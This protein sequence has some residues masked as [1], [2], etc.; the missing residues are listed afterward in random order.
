MK[1]YSS[2]LIVLFFS[3]F[4]LIKIFGQK[5]EKIRYKADELQYIRIK[6]EPVRKLLNNVIFTQGLT[7]IKCDSAYYF[8]KQKIMEA[9]SNVI[10]TDKDSVIITANKLIYNGNKKY[11]DL[12]GDV[13]YRKKN[14]VLKTKNLV[15][16][17]INK[18]GKFR[19]KGRLSDQQNILI[20]DFGEFNSDNNYSIFNKN[21]ELISP[22]YTL[23]SDTL[24]YYSDSKIAYTYGPTEII[25]KDS[26]IVNAN[27]GEFFTDIKFTEFEKS[28][29]ETNEYF[30]EAD[31]IT[32]DE[33]KEY[34]SALGNVKLIS[35]F[36]NYIITG[37]K[38]FVDKQNNITKVYE[39]P[40]L[41]KIIPYDTF[42]LSSDTIIAFENINYN[43]RKIVAFNNVK[44]IK[45]G[46]EGKADSI[47]YLLKDSLITMFNQ[48]IIWNENNQ[49]TSDTIDFLLV[50]NLIKK[51]I[52]NKNSFIISL[53][54]I[55]NYNQIKG[56]N[57]VSY[58]D[59]NNYINNIQVIGNGESIYFALNEKK[60]SIIGLNYMIC[61]DMNIR[62]E[63]NEIKDITFFKNPKA[64]LIPPHEINE[65]DL[66]L[67][68]F[69]WREDERPNLE[70]VVYYFRKRIYLRN[71]N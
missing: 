1:N 46:L 18:I 70:D 30:L 56:R 13:V 62:F 68:G 34:Y 8:N 47:S 6:K 45:K 12:S 25:T 11:A 37:T 41:K 2:I 53:D 52:L 16:D 55:N 9:Y 20:S 58:F 19:N 39:N 29:I 71:E 35:K 31:E 69:L 38:G 44:I 21:V 36:S 14:N 17:F 60:N 32:L 33:S 7:T 59:D 57:M 5:K 42:Y 51:M 63:N 28:S 26:V 50:N 4:P 22:D 49:I 65:E 61:S 48:P 23:K 15:Y 24:K 3:L 64:K 54:T 10:I 43:E 67:K 40:I 27:G 66:H